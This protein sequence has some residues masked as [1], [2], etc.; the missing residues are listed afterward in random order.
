MNIVVT[1]ALRAHMQ[2][3]GKNVIIVEVAKCDSSDLEV[4]ELHSHL[5][6]EKAAA[7]FIKRQGFRS[8][9]IPEGQV[10]L[11]KYRLEYADDVVFDVKKVLFITMVK[12]QGI[13]L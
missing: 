1:P 4:T 12:C 10:L 5:I 11:P 3:T 9:S 8:L 13:A 6:S 2:K 7:G